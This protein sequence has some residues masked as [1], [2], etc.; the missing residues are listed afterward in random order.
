[1]QRG[2]CRDSAPDSYVCVA[3]ISGGE[4][5]WGSEASDQS[6]GPQ[7]VCEA[8]ALQ[9]GGPLSSPDL[10]QPGDWMTKIDLKDA[11]LK[12]PIHSSQQTLLTFLWEEKYFKFTCLLFSLTSAPRV[13]MKLKPVVG[14]LRQVGFCLV[15]YLDD[16]LI[17]HRDKLQLQQ[18][19][20]L[21]CQLFECLGL[22]VNRKKSVLQPT[23]RLEFLGSEI[24]T[25]PM[26]LSIPQEKRRKIQQDACR[27]LTKKQQLLYKPY[28]QHPFITGT[29]IPDENNTGLF[30]GGSNH[31]VQHSGAI[32]LDQQVRPTMMDIS[33]REILVNSHYSS[34]SISDLR[35]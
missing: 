10:L 7:S 19:I 25:Q 33:R 11:Y 20:P 2:R 24:Y 14:F 27:L 30:T 22:I 35:V 23:Q 4:E 29:T 13:F 34:S 17:V 21:T 26:T 16:L 5:G 15:M 9:D 32:K 31:Q 28:Q 3:D 6:E 8:R 18:M 12:V 1:M